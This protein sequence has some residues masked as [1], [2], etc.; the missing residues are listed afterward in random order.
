MRSAAEKYGVVT[1]MGNQIQAHSVYRTAVKLVHDGAIGKVKDADGTDMAFFLIPG[2]ET[3]EK[4]LS[5]YTAD[6]TTNN[7]TAD[8][9]S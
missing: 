8:L 1:Q 9:I 5:A 7:Q 4:T 3:S 2:L 6:V